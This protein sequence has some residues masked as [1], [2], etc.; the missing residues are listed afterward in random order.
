MF[1]RKILHISRSGVFENG[2][3]LLAVTDELE[4]G[5]YDPFRL[6]STIDS[7]VAVAV[8]IV[9]ESRQNNVSP[10]TI[11]KERFLQGI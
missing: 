7:R 1:K 5:G 6:E 4:E 2:G 3:G 10:W 11:I 9:R 8:E